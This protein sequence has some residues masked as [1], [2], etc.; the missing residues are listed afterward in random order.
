MNP[1]WHQVGMLSD[2]PQQGSRVVKTNQWGDIALFRTISDRVYALADRC[3]HRGGPL[4]SGMVHGEKV[5][6]PLHGW[7]LDLASGEALGAD[8]GCSDHFH[9]KIEEGRVYLALP[10]RHG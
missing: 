2:I 5:T 3:P 8:H 9:I 6:C 4:S 1:Q 10:N 7:T